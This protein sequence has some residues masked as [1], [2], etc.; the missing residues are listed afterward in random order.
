[1]R[2]LLRGTL[3]YHS[4]AKYRIDWDRKAPSK[5]AQHTKDFIQQHFPNDIWFE[6]YCLPR[7]RL[8]IDYLNATR[9]I[10]IEANG[11]QHSSYL[12]FFHK[13]RLGWAN[14]FKRDVAKVEFLEANGYK[15]IEIYDE[16]LPLTKDFFRE[17]GISV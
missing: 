9:K 7:S 11:R 6:E 16:D 8:R 1:M 5:I 12:E 4:D 3:V 15:V 13:D 2:W 10:A 17:F 14:S